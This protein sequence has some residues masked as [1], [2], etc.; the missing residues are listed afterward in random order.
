MRRLKAALMIF[1]LAVVSVV[2]QP[3]TAQAA[4]EWY[5]YPVYIQNVNS[6]KCLVA[7][8]GQDSMV[9]QTGCE[10][11]SS[12]G[13]TDQRWY[14]RMETYPGTSSPKDYQFVNVMS[15]LCLTVRGYMRNEPAVVAPCDFAQ[16]GSPYW[17]DQRWIQPSIGAMQNRHSQQCLVGRGGGLDQPPPVQFPCDPQLFH[18]QLW[19]WWPVQ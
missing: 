13:W 16:S 17:S 1:G 10:P 14:V 19:N 7:R 6:S 3:Q 8:G 4:V 5:P 9:E 12:W 15:G 2:A 11:S 18:D